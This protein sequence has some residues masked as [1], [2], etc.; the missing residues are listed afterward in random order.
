MAIDELQRIRRRNDAYWRRREGRL[1]AKI[2][3][4]AVTELD[5][6]LARQYQRAGK[7]IR[8]EILALLK[9]LENAEGEILPSDLY[10]GG[11][12]FEMLNQVN[13]EL[14]RLGYKQIEAVDR[15]LLEVY[16]E[17]SKLTASEFGLY[18]TVDKDAAR[19]VIN[20]VW[21]SDGKDLSDRIWKNKDM[22]MQR[23]EDGIFDFVSKGQPTA[24]MTSEIMSMQLGYDAS[25]ANLRDFDDAM[26]EDFQE[27]YH[28]AQ[29]LVRTETARVQNRATQD[30][31]KEAGFTKWRVIAEPDCCEVCE[32]LSKEVFDIDQLVIPAHP[33]CRCAMAA[34]TESLQ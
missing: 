32:D 3:D 2:H 30:R 13:N 25:R 14:Q 22:L 1:R 21:C 34:I 15:K 11:R 8:S 12:Y 18:S 31:Y 17:Q 24:D 28:N 23:L 20:E 5:A 19:L 9:E 33:N 26:L 16:E 27:A 4:T 29:R 10:K 7:R 6:E